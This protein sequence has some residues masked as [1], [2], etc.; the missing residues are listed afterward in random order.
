MLKMSQ[1]IL[2]AALVI[3]LDVPVFLSS[4]SVYQI[5]LIWFFMTLAGLATGSLLL[6]LQGISVAQAPID[7][8][9][10]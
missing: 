2:R 4:L 10:T 1:A 5:A 6:R 9:K 7:L 8:I 3:G